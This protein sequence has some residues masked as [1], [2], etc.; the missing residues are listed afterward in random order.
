MIKIKRYYCPKFYIRKYI[1]EVDYVK[2]CLT[3]DVKGL[4]RKIDKLEK[5]IKKLELK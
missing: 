4:E 2:V 1:Y 5:T 3:S